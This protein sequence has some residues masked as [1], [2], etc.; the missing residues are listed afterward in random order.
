MTL[1]ID[2]HKGISISFYS[3]EHDPIHVHGYYE[4]RSMGMKAEIHL[5]D[6][7]VSKIAYK[8]ITK[9]PLPARQ[10]RDF[11]DYVKENADDIIE[12]WVN[13]HILNKPIKKRKK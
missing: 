1:L 2:Y 5:K 12:D 7:K 8:K 4:G 11:E 10:Q 9:K 3:N 6:G 13:Y